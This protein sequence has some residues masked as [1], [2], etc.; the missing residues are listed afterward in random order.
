MQG[1]TVLAPKVSVAMSKEMDWTFHQK[2]LNHASNM[3]TFQSHPNTNW[4]ILALHKNA[5]HLQCLSSSFSS[6][7]DSVESSCMVLLICTTQVR[8]CC[9]QMVSCFPDTDMK[10]YM[11]LLGR[12]NQDDKK[13]I[14]FLKFWLWSLC[15]YSVPFVF[16]KTNTYANNII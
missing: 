14:L 10:G 16:V 3:V 8:P 6:F 7:E 13:I 5:L 15:M 1:N 2:L 11:T 12:W 9:S 4:L